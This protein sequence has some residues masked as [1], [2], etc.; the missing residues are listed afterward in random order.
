MLE[1]ENLH[2]Y[3]GSSH[4]LHG[5]SLQVEPGQGVCLLGRNGAGKSTTMKSVIGLG[6]R[7]TGNLRFR[8]QN[9]A[10]LRPYRRVWLGLGY[11]PEDRRIYPDLTVTENLEIGRYAC[12]G[13]RHPLSLDEVW[14]F[15]PLLR[16]L[17]GRLG[18]ELSG[19]EQQLLSVAR[20]MV[21][22]PEVLLLDEPCEGLAPLIVKALGDVI[23]RTLTEKKMAVL[24]AE[25]NVAFALGLTRYVYVIESGQL[26]YEG[27]TAEFA[28]QPELQR[29]FLAV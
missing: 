28:R 19:G 20:T 11:V 1:V 16:E 25:Q 17:K 29:R 14:S 18:K 27:S 26:V 7:A 22:Q 2:A 8:R 12:G 21:G 15:F 4:V 3:Y 24:L 6:P 13:Q 9:L 23:R 10:G 5:I